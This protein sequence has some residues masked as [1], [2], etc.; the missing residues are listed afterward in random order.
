M[1]TQRYSDQQVP[2]N[3]KIHNS[4]RHL[5]PPIP[6]DIYETCLET[7]RSAE[8]EKGVEHKIFLLPVFSV[9]SV[10]LW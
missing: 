7:Q 6:E 5:N 3:S 1:T 9:F 2:L 10:P 4:L 8:R